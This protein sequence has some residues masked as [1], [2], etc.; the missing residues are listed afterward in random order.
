MA[1]TKRTSLSQSYSPAK[2]V[3]KQKWGKHINRAGLYVLAKVLLNELD[4]TI[5]NRSRQE[6]HLTDCPCIWLLIL[7]AN[8]GLLHLIGTEPYTVI[9]IGDIDRRNS[10]WQ[11]GLEDIERFKKRMKQGGYD[12]RFAQFDIAPFV[13]N[14]RFLQERASP[15]DGLLRPIKSSIGFPH[16]HW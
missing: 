11:S 5:P 9:G 10:T 14:L 15:Y 13:R 2:E 6:R 12:K 4:P 1:M 8:E 7:R 3:L 16:G